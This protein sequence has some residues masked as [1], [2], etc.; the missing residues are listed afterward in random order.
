M[1]Y[2]E[3]AREL[4]KNDHFAALTGIVIN[5]AEPGSVLCS[6]DIEQR[7]RNAVGGVMGGVIFT[8]ADF[9]FAVAANIGGSTVVSLTSNI[10]YLSKLKGVTLYAQATCVKSGK[11][12]C[13]YAVEIGDNLDTHIATVSITGF[14]C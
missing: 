8:L 13:V 6:V 7:H 4:F 2:L 3:K 14:V 1:N 12:T 11:S 5:E 10:T 9:A